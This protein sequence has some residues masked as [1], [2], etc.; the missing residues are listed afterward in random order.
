[1]SAIVRNQFPIIE[2]IETGEKVPTTRPDAAMAIGTLENGAL[3]SV[4]IEGAQH[5][6]TGLQ[7]DIT[8]TEGVLR[9]TNVLA[10]LNKEDNVIEGMRGEAQSFSPL[11]VPPEYRPLADVGLDVSQQDVAYLYRAYA[12]DR[13][14]GTS[15]A[16]NFADAV[17]QHQLI[18]EMFN[19]SRRTFG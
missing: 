2:V 5:Q 8:G 10:F 6:R 3:F 12:Q 9:V 19:T 16:A 4:Q 18:D 7:I 14:D 15:T 17:R 1:M 11:P 13:S